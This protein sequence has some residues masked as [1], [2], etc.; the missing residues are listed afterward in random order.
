MIDPRPIV[1][2]PSRKAARRRCDRP[3]RLRTIFQGIW[4]PR[5]KRL[6]SLVPKGRIELPTY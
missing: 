5:R 3:R 2:P 6:E 1:E 4:V